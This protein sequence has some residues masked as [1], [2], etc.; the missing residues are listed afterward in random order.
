[1]NAEEHKKLLEAFLIEK[2]LGGVPYEIPNDTGG[3]AF[4]HRDYLAEEYWKPMDDIKQAFELVDSGLNL[5]TFKLFIAVD[6]ETS[7][8]VW[9]CHLES[10]ADPGHL[11]TGVA[12]GKTWA[13]CRAVAALFGWDEYIEEYKKANSK[14]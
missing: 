12:T 11:Y 10:L 13:I 2:V 9:H 1:M 4:T 5:T 3:W 6:P 8:F 7:K 14:H